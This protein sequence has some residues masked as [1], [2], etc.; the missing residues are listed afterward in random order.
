MTALC[1]GKQLG[2]GLKRR[3]GIEARISILIKNFIGDKPRAKGFEHRQMMVGWGVL[4][5]NLWVVA[6]L[7]QA[8]PEQIEAVA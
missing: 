8:P 5:H 7:K 6:R 3:A 4:A 1:P 2:A